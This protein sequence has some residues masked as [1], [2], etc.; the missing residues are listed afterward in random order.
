MSKRH[1]DL[2][3]GHERNFWWN[4]DFLELMA[5]RLNL[6]TYS[7]VLDVGCGVGHWTRTLASLMPSKVQF[8]GVDQEPE[9][10]RQ[11]RLWAQEH[12]LNKNFSF[13][14]GDANHLPFKDETFEL[15]TCQT[16]LIHCAEPKK[17]L[18]EMLRVL[19]PG[20]LILCVEP[21][22]LANQGVQSSIRMHDD[23]DTQIKRIA[24]FCR[25]QRGKRNL[26]EGDLSFGDRL[27]GELNAL[28]A[29]NISVYTSDKTSTLVPPYR[30]AGAAALTDAIIR[31]HEEGFLGWHEDEVERYF[32]A[33]GGTPAELQ[34]Y[35]LLF[36]KDLECSVDALRRN[37]YHCAG[38]DVQYLVSAIK[39]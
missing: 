20:G 8:T 33:G 34:D 32:L 29:Q 6:S 1:S 7:S 35:K 36:R 37:E 5:K 12:D 2:Y 9:W 28:G 19:K 16:L 4:Q 22:N 31:Q 13:K 24:Y 18:R 3:F 21:S 27:P 15:V 30:D 11:N 39:A 38:G 17:V 10:I 23:I 14:L 26:G 25:I